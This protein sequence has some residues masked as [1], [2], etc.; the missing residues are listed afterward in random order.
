MMSLRAEGDPK[1]AKPGAPDVYSTM[2]GHFEIKK[3]RM[4]SSD[5]DYDLPGASVRLSGVYSLG[6]RHQFAGKV[7]TKAK[8]SQ[9]VE[10]K[11]KSIILKPVDPFFDKHGAGAEIPVK[12]SGTGGSPHLGLKPGGA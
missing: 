1:Q 6:K 8:L 4:N 9:M 2:T 7:R 12:I 10:S 5:L 11:W 3:G